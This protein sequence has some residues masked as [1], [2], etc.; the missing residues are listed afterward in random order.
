MLAAGPWQLLRKNLNNVNMSALS[1]AF[2]VKGS[3]FC[4]VCN[5]T[6]EMNSCMFLFLL[7]EYLVSLQARDGDFR[8]HLRNRSAIPHWKIINGFKKK[9]L[10]TIGGFH[11]HVIEN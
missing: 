4:T 10:Q 2:F 5:I 7:M 9:M 3:V 1:K 6:S 11:C 8:R